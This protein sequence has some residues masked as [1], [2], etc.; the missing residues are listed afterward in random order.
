MEREKK[1]K[2]ILSAYKFYISPGTLNLSEVH[3]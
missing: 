3:T 2:G 1:R